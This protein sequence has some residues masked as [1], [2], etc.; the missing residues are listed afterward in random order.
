MFPVVRTAR[1]PSAFLAGLYRKQTPELG[2]LCE[3]GCEE[4]LGLAL[5]LQSR[6]GFSHVK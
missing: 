2:Q 4:K 5:F 1:G 3:L 6:G